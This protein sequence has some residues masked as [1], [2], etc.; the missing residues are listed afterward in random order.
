MKNILQYLDKHDQLPTCKDPVGKLTVP[1][2][3]VFIE[4]GH[5]DFVV[6][7]WSGT[8]FTAF[9]H[10]SEVPWCVRAQQLDSLTIWLTALS[11]PASFFVFTFT[12]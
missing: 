11:S 2:Q 7:K 1:L 4:A 3:V 12:W 8:C 6:S 5:S 9:I 10:I